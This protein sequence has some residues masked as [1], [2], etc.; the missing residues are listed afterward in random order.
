MVKRLVDQTQKGGRDRKRGGELTRHLALTPHD[1]IDNFLRWLTC[2]PSLQLE[3]LG[4][5][6]VE[7]SGLAASMTLAFQELGGRHDL[8]GHGWRTEGKGRACS[9]VFSEAL[10]SENIGLQFI[11]VEKT[12]SV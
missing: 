3:V 7:R 12:S 9:A 11:H 2:V 5:H 1:H 10:T 4:K 6:H 8:S